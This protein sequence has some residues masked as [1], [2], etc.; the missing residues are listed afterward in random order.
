MSDKSKLDSLIFSGGGLVKRGYTYALANIGKT[1]ALITSVAVLLLTFG[2][3]GF[4]DLKRDSFT[5]TVLVM[6]VASYVIYFS[7]HDAGE[8][9]GRETDVY[10]EAEKK[11]LDFRERI[12]Y[13]DA[14]SLRAF[15]L[16]YSK[17]EL[18]YRRKSYIL[19]QG[20][21]YSEYSEYLSGK[22]VG[23]RDGRIYR[24]AASMKA[25]S[26]TPRDLRERKRSERRAELTS[27]TSGKMLRMILSMIP[28]TLGTLFTVS[29]MLGIKEGL[30]VETV[31][32]SLV[33]L[34]A[35][36]IVALRAYAHGY[37]F[38]S[39]DVVSW[40]ETKTR[41]IEEY[42]KSEGQNEREIGRKA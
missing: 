1:V 9:A 19:S 40:M 34:S 41:I 25:V 32:E 22:A 33:R 20:A 37:S 35:L 42:L 14:A 7:L 18:E 28:T 39:E 30:T 31:I 36:P 15:L 2:E 24:R 23:G 5:A 27:P 4:I 16:Q 29:L 11:Y 17:D 26:I 13:K 21:S 12:A 8:G 3:V 38:A 10:K 6:L